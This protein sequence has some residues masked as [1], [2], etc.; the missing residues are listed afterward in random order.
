MNGLLNMITSLTTFVQGPTGK[1]PV[2]LVIV[3]AGVAMMSGKIPKMLFYCIIGGIFLIFSAS[4]IYTNVLGIGSVIFSMENLNISILYSA[5][6][7]PQMWLGI[8]LFLIPYLF[9]IFIIFFIGFNPLYGFIVLPILWV[10]GYSIGKIDPDFTDTI[11]KIIIFNNIP[12]TDK[13]RSIKSLR[14]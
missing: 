12:I 4:Y 9:I 13:N 10:F 14:A 11:F 8:P 2:I 3:I 6:L 7:R 5:M 1:A